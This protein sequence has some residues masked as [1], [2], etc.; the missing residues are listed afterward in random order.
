MA[1]RERKRKRDS[2]RDVA[3]GKGR[4]MGATQREVYVRVFLCWC[5]ERE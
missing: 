2:A 4:I 1:L 3:R 5:G